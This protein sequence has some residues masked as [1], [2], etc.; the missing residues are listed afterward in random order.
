M[1]NMSYCRFE[2]T[3]NDLRDCERAL[4]DGEFDKLG[5]DERAAALSL[6]RRCVRI[7]EKFCDVLENE[8]AA[9]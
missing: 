6:I 8:E 1:A 9:S 3:D 5:A 4:D 2:N 7:C